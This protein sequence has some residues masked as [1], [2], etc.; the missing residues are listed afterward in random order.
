[1]PVLAEAECGYTNRIHVE[2]LV[3]ICLA[4]AE[5]GEA[6]NVYNVSDGHPGNMTQYFNAVADAVGLP[7]PPS[8]PMAEAQERLSPA[9]LSYLTESRRMDNRKLLRDFAFT[10]R[11]PQL[12]LGLAALA[13]SD[14]M[15]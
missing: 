4:A 7:R 6:D 12:A 5:K 1:L 11:Y 9:M 2:D 15:S 14:G 3:R 8:I 10:L 13:D